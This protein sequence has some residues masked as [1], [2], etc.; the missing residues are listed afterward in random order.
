MY[1]YVEYVCVWNMYVC[2]CVCGISLMYVC[3]C[4]MSLMYVCMYMWNMYVYVYV[5]YVCVC[6]V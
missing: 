3:I 4:G 5:E 2:V 1:V 6:K